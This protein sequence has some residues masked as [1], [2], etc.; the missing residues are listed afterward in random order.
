MWFIILIDIEKL[1]LSMRQLAPRAKGETTTLC[2]HQHVCTRVICGDLRG[3]KVQF[4]VYICTSVTVSEI[5]FSLAVILVLGF[6][7]F[8]CRAFY[9]SGIA[10]TLLS[11]LNMLYSRLQVF[12]LQ[13]VS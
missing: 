13:C 7:T 12:L 10:C 5:I 8:S 9:Q 1:P 4:E 11:I 6:P 2:S 3:E